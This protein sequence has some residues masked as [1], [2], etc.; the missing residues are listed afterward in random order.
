MRELRKRRSD[1]ILWPRVLPVISRGD[2]SEV[3][4]GTGGRDD[5]Q[6]KALGEVTY[7]PVSRNF[8]NKACAGSLVGPQLIFRRLLDVIDEDYVIGEL[9]RSHLQAELLLHGGI[10]EEKTRFGL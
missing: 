8:G 10:K 1:S 5:A 7:N 3:D 2:H 6:N 9:C 4:R